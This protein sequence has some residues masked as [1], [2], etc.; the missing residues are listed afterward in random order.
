MRKRA[1]QGR[2]EGQDRQPP[3]AEVNE[4]RMT[5]GYPS[6]T[7]LCLECGYDRV[8]AGGREVGDSHPLGQRKQT[9]ADSQSG[10]GGVT[11]RVAGNYYHWQMAEDVKQGY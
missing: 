8:K 2:M 3:T 9:L 6:S 10:R 4:L 11:V 7:R 5:E 1:S